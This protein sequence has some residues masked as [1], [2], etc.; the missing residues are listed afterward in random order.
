[1]LCQLNAGGNYCQL[2]RKRIHARQDL[3]NKIDVR[4]L[5]D[6]KLLSHTV[7]PNYTKD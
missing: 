6:Y 7:Y 1:M 4:H 2:F 3:E 5:S